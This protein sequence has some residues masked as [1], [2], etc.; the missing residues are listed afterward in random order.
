MFVTDT[1]IYTAQGPHKTISNTRQNYRD[2][3]L[4]P[5]AQL[6]PHGHGNQCVQQVGLEDPRAL[7]KLD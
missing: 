7:S 1:V 6:H 4:R 5:G 2:A 3:Q